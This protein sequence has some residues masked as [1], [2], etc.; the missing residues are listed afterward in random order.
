MH[1]LI[2]FSNN[3]KTEPKIE[4]LLLACFVLHF[5][6]SALSSFA[7]CLCSGERSLALY[8]YDVLEKVSM[9]S[10]VHKAEYDL[11]TGSS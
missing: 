7:A 1:H 6:L 11:R 4:I 10:V 9:L 3:L 2:F 8:V 5:P